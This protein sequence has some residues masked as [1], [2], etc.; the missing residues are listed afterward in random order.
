MKQI[1]QVDITHSLLWIFGVAVFLLILFVILRLRDN[2][3]IFDYYDPDT[4][5]CKYCGQSYIKWN[6][7]SGRIASSI[8]IVPEY[9]EP[10]DKK[11]Q[12]QKIINPEEYENS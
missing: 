6:F 9:K 7:R 3:R 1:Y 4:K 5:V 12:C 10:V 11:C 2:E 8:W